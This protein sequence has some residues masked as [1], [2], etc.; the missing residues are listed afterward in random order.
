M[1]KP[2]ATKKDAAIR[3]DT[4]RGISLKGERINLGI[5]L[6][7]LDELLRNPLLFE[8]VFHEA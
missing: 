6:L 8:V 4:S 1:P 3:I 5:L 7:L 2:T